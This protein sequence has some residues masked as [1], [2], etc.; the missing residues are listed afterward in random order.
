MIAAQ[1]L[2]AIHV[3][4]TVHGTSVHK[5][6]R[7][8]AGCAA[9][10]APGDRLPERLAPKTQAAKSK[11]STPPAFTAIGS[12]WTG[13]AIVHQ[14]RSGCGGEHIIAF[15]SLERIERYADLRFKRR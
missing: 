12:D 1:T 11:D 9:K 4:F 2:A 10:V 3:T 13:N 7:A 15:A 14:T 5:I 6:W 8:G